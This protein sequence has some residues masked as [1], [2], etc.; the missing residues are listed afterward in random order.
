MAVIAK[1]H[2]RRACRRQSNEA[3]HQGCQ[4]EKKTVANLTS[5]LQDPD[6]E[7]KSGRIFGFFWIWIGLDIVSLTTG[8][9]LSKWYKMW[10]CKKSWHGI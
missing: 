6:F 3:W 4:I 8:S 7:V 5:G 9:G 10:T 1:A 2:R